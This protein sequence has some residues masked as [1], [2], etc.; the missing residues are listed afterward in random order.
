MA[1][2]VSAAAIASSAKVRLKGRTELRI[3]FPT[4]RT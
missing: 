4:V 2:R 3:E 1:T